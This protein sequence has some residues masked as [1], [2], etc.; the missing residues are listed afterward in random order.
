MAGSLTAV[1]SRILGGHGAAARSAASALRHRAG[2]ALPVGSH[3]VPDRPLPVNEKLVWENGTLFPE[4]CVDCLAPHIGK[5]EALAWLYG[6]LSFFAVLGFA[7]AVNDKA[8]KMPLMPKVYPYD[9]LRVEL[10][11]GDRS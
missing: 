5:Y 8:S 7:A 1:G 6:G 9:N 4:P 11:V 3:I 10:G 2:M